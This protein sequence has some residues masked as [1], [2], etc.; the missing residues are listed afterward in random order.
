MPIDGNIWLEDPLESSYPPSIAF[1]AAK[2][3]DG[4]KA[5]KF[6]RRI[7]EM[8][9]IGKKNITRFEHLLQAAI[10]QGLDK[11]RFLRDY[12]NAA[13]D[14]FNADLAFTR[15]E[16][17]RGFPTFFFENEGGRQLRV[18][19]LVSYERLEQIISGLYPVAVKPTTAHSA[20]SIFRRYTSITA[21]EFSV[22]AGKSI[23]ESEEILDELTRQ[24]K[25]EKIP[26]R[27]GAIWKTR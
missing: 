26:S 16:G 7:R 24:N 10:E 8:L 3:Q 22:M 19:G 11:E 4:D 21:K 14:L 2:M 17:V 15:S 1:I 12:E 9:F 23:K 6:L 20:T 13:V 27:N 25:L 18:S 5:E